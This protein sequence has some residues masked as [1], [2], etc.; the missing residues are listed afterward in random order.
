MNQININVLYMITKN[1]VQI[2]IF[3]IKNQTHFQIN[4]IQHKPLILVRYISLKDNFPYLLSIKIQIH[5]KRY[6]GYLIY[7]ISSDLWTVSRWILIIIK[8]IVII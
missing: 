3:F 1:K 5:K 8:N 2:M 6:G 4:N 7:M